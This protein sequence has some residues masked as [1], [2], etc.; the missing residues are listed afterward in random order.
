MTKQEVFIQWLKIAFGVYFAW[1][2]WQIL[3]KLNLLVKMI[4]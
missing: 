4:E 3:D 2:G 1:L